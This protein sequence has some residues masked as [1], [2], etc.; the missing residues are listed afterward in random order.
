MAPDTTPKLTRIAASMD[1]MGKLGIPVKA[2]CVQRWADEIAA[3]ASPAPSAGVGVDA[4]KVAAMRCARRAYG[5]W[6]GGDNGSGEALQYFDGGYAGRERDATMY[7]AEIRA[8]LSQHPAAPSEEGGRSPRSIIDDLDNLDSQ[9]RHL[10]GVSI[11]NGERRITPEGLRLSVIRKAGHAVMDTPAGSKAGCSCCGET[12]T[13]V[14]AFETLLICDSCWAKAKETAEAPSVSPAEQEGVCAKCGAPTDPDCGHLGDCSPAVA[15]DGLDPPVECQR[16]MLAE[17]IRNAA[18]KRGIVRADASLTGPMLLLLCEDLATSEASSAPQGEAVT[19]ETVGFVRKNSDGDLYVDW[20]PEGGIHALGEGCELIASAVK[21]TDD[22]GAGE[23]YTTPPPAP[24]AE[25]AADPFPDLRNLVDDWMERGSIMPSDDF[26]RELQALLD[27][28]TGD[29]IRALVYARQQDNIRIS[30]EDDAAEQPQGEMVLVPREPTDEMLDAAMAAVKA[31]TVILDAG[32]AKGATLVRDPHYHVYR[33]M[34]SA[35]P[36]R[37][38]VDEADI[39]AM[40][41]VYLSSRQRE[42]YDRI[43]AAALA[44]KEGVA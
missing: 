38:V 34:L 29:D 22:T 6:R 20:T 30:R 14:I 9:M 32:P 28:M 44:G 40:R 1:R 39:D 24:A 31:N 43:L 3:L 27:S 4:I 21:L 16:D 25:Q 33:A 15:G 13:H 5:F 10:H 8:A 12:F 17:A 41:D 36:S 23:V 19:V 35:A 42:A 26:A 37:P 7:E 11:V 18:V 2:E